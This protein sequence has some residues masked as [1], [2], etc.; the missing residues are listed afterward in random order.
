MKLNEDKYFYRRNIKISLVISLIVIIAAFTISFLTKNNGNPSRGKKIRYF[1]EPIITIDD[2]P[3]TRLMNQPP[4]T[5]QTKQLLKSKSYL[6]FVPSFTNFIIDE[7][8]LLPDENSDSNTQLTNNEMNIY[9]NT[10]ASTIKLTAMQFMPQQILEVIPRNDDNAKGFIKIK[11][12][13]GIN[14]L[15][16]HY[17]I[18]DNTLNSEKIIANVIDAVLKSKWQPIIIEGKRIEYWIE[19]TYT[20]NLPTSETA[21]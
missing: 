21:K 19:K 17:E 11:L 10:D 8:T 7:P 14:G 20:F 9:L 13:I 16:K 12:L 6:S 18:L 2:I 1:Y 3:K 15:I 4:L 5:D